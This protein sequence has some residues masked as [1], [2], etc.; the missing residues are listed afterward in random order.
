MK[1]KNHKNNRIE[2]LISLLISVMLIQCTSDKTENI[3]IENG[4][5]RYEIGQE[6][7]N[8]HFTDKATGNDYLDPAAVSYCAYITQDGK[9]Q[10][11][12]SVSLKGKHLLLEFGNADVTAD[13]LVR[14]ANDLSLI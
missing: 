11:V 6:G 7:K 12:T 14:K 2:I 9:Q 5:F 1:T 4:S 13:V 3:V 8:L 10:N